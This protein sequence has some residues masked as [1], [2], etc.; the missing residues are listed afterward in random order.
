MMYIESK[1]L[2][3]ARDS[4]EEPSATFSVSLSVPKVDHNHPT[5]YPRVL[6][7]CLFSVHCL[8]HLFHM[9]H[10]FIHVP[11]QQSEMFLLRSAHTFH[12]SWEN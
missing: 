5:H 9:S 7:R 6:N 12:R 8:L 3:S 2:N 1:L 11:C 4:K 10:R